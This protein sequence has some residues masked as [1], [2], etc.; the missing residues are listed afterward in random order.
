MISQDDVE[1][2]VDFI[3]DHASKM[4][5]S[6]ATVTYLE[7]YRKSKKALLIQKA[8]KGTVSERESFAYAHPE[9]L[10]VLDGLRA[11]VE[12]HETL[13]WLM[14]AAQTKIEAWQTQSAN[15]RRF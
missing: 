2:A 5:V 11:A 4:G 9:Y 14:I 12:E 3:R 10:E 6:K 13:R 15:E 1:K 8:G 7:E